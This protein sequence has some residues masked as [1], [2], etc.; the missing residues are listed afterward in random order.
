MESQPTQQETSAATQAGGHY[1][2]PAQQQLPMPMTGIQFSEEQQNRIFM[3][4]ERVLLANAQTAEA[5]ARAAAAAADGNALGATQEQG[6]LADSQLLAPIAS[7]AVLQGLDRSLI[8][9][10]IVNTF[11]PADLWKLRTCK[12]R[13]VQKE[14]NI[15]W[16][17]GCFVE[18]PRGNKE[19]GND[20]SI[21]R[22]GFSNYV[23]IMSLLYHG[24]DHVNLVSSMLNFQ[25]QIL[26]L[27]KT[28]VWQSC[29]LN[30]ALKY[31]QDRQ[32]DSRTDSTKWD[33]IPEQ[34]QAIY[35]DSAKLRFNNQ[36]S[37]A[38]AK[39]QRSDATPG[40][41]TGKEIEEQICHAWNR[42]E[43]CP[44]EPC[45][46]KPVCQNRDCGERHKRSKCPKTK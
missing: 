16:E 37:S 24:E 21:W 7:R 44:S 13:A 30:M 43:K 18:K 31:H 12:D 45:Q 27:E 42:D 3:L 17:N 2:L 8:S 11:E 41:R 34:F 1:Q 9:K 14:K 25:R 33:F 19:F 4:Q 5:T 20:F 15:V 39:R 32:Y 40:S 36:T 22:E 29:I 38:G 46:R 23:S 35:L 10:V 6:K 28:Y 26:R